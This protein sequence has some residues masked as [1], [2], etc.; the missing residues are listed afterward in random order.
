MPRGGGIDAAIEKTL[1]SE[2]LCVDMR[3]VF[4]D[5][6]EILLSSGGVWNREESPAFVEG[7]LDAY[8]GEAQT[9]SVIEIHPGQRAAVE[10]F[11]RWLT[12]HAVRRVHRPEFS[13]T[14]LDADHVV[15]WNPEHAYSALF[16]GGRRAGKSWIAV[17]LAVAYAIMFPKAIVWLVAPAATDDK[18]DELR[19][20]FVD[21]APAEWIDHETVDGWDLLNGS[22]VMLKG[23][24]AADGLKTGEAHFILLNEGQQMT[25]RAYTVARGAIVDKSG[26]VLVCANPPTE[27]GDHQ[28]VTDFAAKAAAHE[29][30]SVFVHFNSLLNPHIDRTSLLAMSAEVDERTFAIEVLGEFRGP[31]DAVA[32]NW[33]RLE[34]EKPFPS[35]GNV[36]EAFLRSIEEGDGITH[37]VGLDV[38]RIPYIGGPVYNFYGEPHRD[39]VL[40]WITDE[41]ILDGGDEEDFCAALEEKGYRPESTL[42]VCDASGRYQ[43]SRRRSMDQPP[44]E[45]HG[46]GSFDIIRAAGW[47]RIVPPS[48]IMKRNPE[49]QDRVRAFTS[50]ICTRTGVRRLFADP[51]TAPKACKAIREWKTLH[52]SPSRTQHEAHLGDGVSYPIVRLFPRVLRSTKPGHVDPIA[53]RVDNASSDAPPV[54]RALP[55]ASGPTPSSRRRDRWRGY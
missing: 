52:G 33:I 19:R 11:A 40:A 38:Q 30:A 53:A 16:A 20:Y 29:R 54:L 9:A 28:W 7:G 36:T 46:R 3:I 4:V 2:E 24:Y 31:K 35:H 37:V 45:W 47:Y 49:I 15:D 34:N 50:M 25:E 43:H 51:K 22:R 41:V 6:G 12:A 18:L 10:W 14:D 5:R 1:G 26:L 13:I 48:R 39:R 8:V 23:A 27:T 55:L 17:A 42:I 32:Y 21:T 44:P